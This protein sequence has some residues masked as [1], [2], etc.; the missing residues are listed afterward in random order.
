V[1]PHQN[2]TE[3]AAVRCEPSGRE[4]RVNVE[5]DLLLD[6][7]HEIGMPVSQACD[8][9]ALCG[10]CRVEVLDGWDYLSPMEDEERK[11]LAAL[12]AGGNERLA[13]CARVLG[14][15]TVTTDYWG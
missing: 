9:E 1:G 15:V 4:I 11:I 10:F 3:E 14:A 13:C 8:G 12:H 7:L 2:K 5:S 6:A